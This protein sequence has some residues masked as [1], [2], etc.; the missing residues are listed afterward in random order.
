MLLK[1]SQNEVQHFPMISVFPRSGV[2]KAAAEFLWNPRHMDNSMVVTA[3]LSSTLTLK[4]R[5]STHGMFG[6]FAQ[7]TSMWILFYAIFL[8]CS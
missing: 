3:T 5:S 1:V 8:S 6:Q 4:G 2:W 7:T